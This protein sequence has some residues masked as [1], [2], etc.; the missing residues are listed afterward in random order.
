VSSLGAHSASPTELKAQ[1]EAEREG[2]PFLVFRDGDGAQQI[3]TLSPV[4]ER[5]T[6][7]RTDVTDIPLA[8]DAS[9]S[10]VHAELMRVAGDWA[11]ADDGLSRYG[12]Y[13]NG[14]RLTG[15]RRLDDGDRIQLGE[16]V[17]VYRSPQASALAATTRNA[18]PVDPAQLSEAQKRVLVALCRPF[19]DGAPYATPASNQQIA[20]ELFLSV[21][22]VK[23]HLRTLFDKFGVGELPHNQKRLKLVERALICGA[24]AERDLQV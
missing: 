12:S 14:Q 1:I 23:G 6:L 5:L 8:W 18:P 19:A 13:V 24:V 10:R 16:V 22:A 2:T 3:I 17:L 20:D 15:R 11:I 21:A 4:R 7:G 9:V